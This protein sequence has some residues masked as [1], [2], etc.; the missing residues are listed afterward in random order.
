[1]IMSERVQHLIA[2]DPVLRRAVCDFRRDYFSIQGLNDAVL[3]SWQD[4]APSETIL[5]R[6]RQGLRTTLH[7]ALAQE[8]ALDDLLDDVEYERAPNPT[9]WERILADEPGEP[10]E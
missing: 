6:N 9:R 3:P 4:W 10:V 2:G 1:M 7:E 5:E 8:R